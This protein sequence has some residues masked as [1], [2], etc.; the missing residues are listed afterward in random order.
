MKM[1]C[2]LISTFFIAILAGLSACKKTAQPVDSTVAAIWEAS[3]YHQTFM[4]P[5]MPDAT[6][7]TSY[8]HG[9]SSV[10]ILKTNNTFKFIDPKLFAGDTISGTYYIIQGASPKIVSNYDDGSFI[11]TF[12]YNVSGNLMTLTKTK[13]FSE[14]GT[15]FSL[16]T[17]TKYTKQ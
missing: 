17:E 6:W 1:S 14:G 7:D 5:G 11:D 3:S 12:G 15:S 9:K 16:K 2:L 10:W 13:D 8:E 4:M